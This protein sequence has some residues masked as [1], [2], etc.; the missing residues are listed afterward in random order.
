MKVKQAIEKVEK[1]KNYLSIIDKQI[2]FYK[3]IPKKSS[4][5]IEKSTELKRIYDDKFSRLSKLLSS[6]VK[7]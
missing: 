3:V 7:E 4:I 6:E 5:Q 2:I 1:I